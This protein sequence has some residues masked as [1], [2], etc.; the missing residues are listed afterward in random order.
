MKS[1]KPSDEVL[2]IILGGGQGARLF[3]LTALRAKAAVPLGGKYRLID[4][5]LSNCINSG[6][7][8]IYILTQ[9]NTAALHRHITH[10]YRFSHF[11]SG[12]TD[13]LP[14]EQT[15][16]HREWYQSS[17]D[18][19]RRAWR[20]FDPWP[21]DTYLILPGDHLYRMDYR[22]LLERHWQT[23]A[24]VTLAIAPVTEEKAG[25]CGLVLMDH[26]GWVREFREQPKGD[27]LKPMQ[28]TVGPGGP[29]RYL[30]SMGIYVFRKEVLRRLLDETQP[31][32]DFGME[33]IPKA[34]QMYRAQTYLFDG[35]WENIGTLAAFY[36]ANLDLTGPEPRFEFYDPVAPIYTRPRFLPPA[37]VRECR[38]T[39]CLVAEGAIL[40]G[41]ELTECIVGVRTR[42]QAGAQLERTILMGCD[43]YQSVEEIEDDRARGR[44]LLGVGKGAVI[45]G[46]IIDKNV[47]IGAAARITNEEGLTHFDGG[48]YVIRDGIVVIPRDAIIPDGQVI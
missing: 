48:H 3:P 22:E 7:E 17:T 41:A 14:T 24:D 23:G 2:G 35:Y 33:L 4:I 46:A 25:Q 6:V 13:I 47:R 19:V 20:H 5:A 36:R 31:V 1:V 44:P 28:V 34:V 26:D 32:F 42:V 21:A 45:R 10:T 11:G 9:F 39:N 40:S 27:A 8:K 29:S 12:F 37:K 43:R 18:A 16:D 38:I 15:V 30:A